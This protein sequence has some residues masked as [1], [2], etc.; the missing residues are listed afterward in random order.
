MCTARTPFLFRELLGN[1][2][3]IEFDEMICYA[4]DLRVVGP[5]L[6]MPFNL[7]ATL[8]HHWLTLA[9]CLTLVLGIMLVALTAKW[10]EFAADAESTVTP[11]RRT[12][13]PSDTA[14]RT[15]DTI[16]LEELTMEQWRARVFAR[17]SVARRAQRA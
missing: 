15:A 1:G 9:E 6:R 12:A 10:A 14:P 16:Q 5:L 3:M 2:P 8:E 11:L 7:L 17:Q 13:R 4:L